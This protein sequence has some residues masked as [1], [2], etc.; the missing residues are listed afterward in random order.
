MKATADSDDEEVQCTTPKLHAS[1]IS[2]LR[3]ATPS[4]AQWDL[5][6][7]TDQ[8]SPHSVCS[9]ETGSA[10]NLA[11]DDSSESEADSVSSEH[12]DVATRENSPSPIPVGS[13]RAASPA[14]ADKKV[15]KRPKVM[16]AIAKALQMVKDAPAKTRMLMF[17]KQSA[18]CE[19][20]LDQVKDATEESQQRLEE[21]EVTDAVKKERKT[22]ERQKKERE[23]ARVWK[24]NQRK[25]KHTK[26]I[27]EGLDPVNLHWEEQMFLS[28]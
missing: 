15:A 1:G 11:T 8:N 3:Y 18:S 22:L 26:E 14:V 23:V 17:F 20:Y 16:S 28:K 13:K 7:T 5:D 6:H 25:R 12:D 21:L 10:Y 19:E 2:D 4:P 27:K 9:T 24:Q